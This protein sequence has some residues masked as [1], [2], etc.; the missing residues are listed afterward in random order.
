MH[1]IR[2]SPLAYYGVMQ[3]VVSE[4]GSSEIR[5]MED[6]REQLHQLLTM[7]EH[8]IPGKLFS[9]IISCLGTFVIIVSHV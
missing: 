1:G 2:V 6:V 9:L 7:S 8:N 3:Q 5:D 4:S